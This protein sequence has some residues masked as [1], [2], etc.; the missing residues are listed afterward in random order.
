[1]KNICPN[2]GKEII[3][4][5]L[6]HDEVNL[7]GFYTNCNKCLASF[8]VDLNPQETFITDI[9]KMT[10]FKILTME[11]FLKAYSYI[12]EEEYEKTKLYYEWLCSNEK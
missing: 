5:K 11:E 9:A 12:S 3:I 6:N 10:D 7:E 2:C 8:D 1:M 4:T